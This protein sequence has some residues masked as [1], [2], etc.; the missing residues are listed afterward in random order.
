VK[1]VF[2]REEYCVGCRLCEIYCITAHSKSKDVIK[3][4]KKENPRP[5]PRVLVEENKPVSFALQCRHCDDNPCVKACITGA[6]HKDENGEKVQYD[7]LLIATGGKP[8]IPPMEGLDKK[9]IYSFIK[10]D[11]VKAIDK[12]IETGKKVV[13]IGAGLIGIKT[14]EALAHC[15]VKVTVIELANRV[16]SAILDEKAGSIVQNELEEHGIRIITENTVQTILGDDEVSGVVLKDRTEISCDFLIVAIGVRPNTGIVSQS[17]IQV[18]RGI[19][20]NERM[21]TSAADIYAAGDCSEGKDIISRQER[22]IPIWPSAYHQGETAGINMA[23]GNYEYQ[24]GFPM[25]SIGFFESHMIT[26]GIIK[27]ENDDYEILS[28]FQPEEK[29]Y[30]KIVLKDNKLVGFIRLGKVGR[31]G[32]LTGLMREKIDVSPFKNKLLDDDFGYIDF[33]KEYRKD[34]MLRGMKKCV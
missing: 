4:F 22:V 28:L 24:G 12:E 19:K 9:K 10:M 27:P 11:D 20:V 18:N 29:I 7:K 23:G 5:L 30:K 32:I 2:V 8:F 25:N 31:A 13:I 14:A 33:S 21:K 26:A 16:L 3:A 15:G 6:M 1:K 17:S 34:K